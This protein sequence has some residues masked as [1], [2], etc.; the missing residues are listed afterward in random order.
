MTKRRPATKQVITITASGAPA[1]SSCTARICAAPE[2]TIAD[3]PSAASGD[4]PAAAAPTPHTRPNGTRPMHAGTI[5]A[6]PARKS[7]SAA[8]RRIASGDRRCLR[9]SRVDDQVLAGDAARFVRGE[10]QRRA[11]DVVLGQPELE[12]LRVDDRRLVGRRHPQRLLARR[13]DRAR[14]ERVDATA[15]WAELAGARA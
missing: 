2:N 6:K 7:A 9:E 4:A 15:A 13:R 10:E 12:A 1:A 5:S 8:M 14:H 3:K 11:R